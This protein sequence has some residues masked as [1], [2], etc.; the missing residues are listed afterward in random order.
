MGLYAR[1][2]NRA[3]NL[4]SNRYNMFD[5]FIIVVL[6]WAIISGWRNGL[7]CELTSLCGHLSGLLVAVI[8]YSMCG[9]Y[10]AVTGTRLSMVTSVV[11][12]FALWIILPIALG[13]AANALTKILRPL[14]LGMINSL[15][16]TIVSLL[17]F[18]VLLSCVLA[19]M[20][21][22][23]ILNQEKAASSRLYNPMKNVVGTVIDWAIDDDIH[24]MTPAEQAATSNGDTLWVDVQ[25]AKD[26]LRRAEQQKSIKAARPAKA[27]N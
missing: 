19:A 6:I 27:N 18:T 16:G 26:S 13:L 24:P 12:F 14:G 10:L 4:L 25:Q 2:Y 9:K 21:A 7:L 11:A 20:N 23:G 8:I 15:G 1:L 22:I 17:K 5:I 3:H